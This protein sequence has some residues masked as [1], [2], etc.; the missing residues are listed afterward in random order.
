MFETISAE[1]GF[2]CRNTKH[3]ADVKA[4]LI[5]CG[6]LNLQMNLPILQGH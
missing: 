5:F 4:P 1:D 3:E 2:L 6:L